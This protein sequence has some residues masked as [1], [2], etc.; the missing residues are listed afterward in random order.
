MKSTDPIHRMIEY[1]IRNADARTQL[2]T[3]PQTLFDDFNIPKSQRTLLL[4]GS[5]DE[6]S[7]E[8]IHPNYVVKWLIWSG[9]PTMPFFPLSYYFDRR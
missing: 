6:L 9:K 2:K 7:A 8:G 3:N 1:L 4:K 5:R